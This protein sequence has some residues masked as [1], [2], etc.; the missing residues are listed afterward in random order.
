MTTVRTA[1]ATPELHVLH[2]SHFAYRHIGPRR[3]DVGE[4]LAVLGYDSI[5]AFIDA[6]V[7][8]GDPAPPPAR[9]C[10]PGRSEREVLQ[11]L[12][13]LAGM[14]RVFRSYIGMGYAGCFTPQVVQRNVLENPGWYTAYTPY[15]AEISQGRLEALLNFQ[16]VVSDL[17]GLRDRQRVA[18]RRGDRRRGGHE[19]DARREQGD[20]AIRSIWWTSTA[21]P[22]TIAVVQTRAEARGIRV[23]V[24]EPETFTFEPGV[25]GALVQ[26]PATDGAVRDFRSLARAGA[27]R[28]RARHRGD[29]SARAHPADAARRMGRRHRGRQQP[30]VRRADGLRRAARG[31]L[32][33]PRGVQ[34]VHARPHHRRLARPRRP[35]RAPHGAADPRAAHPPREGDEQRLHRAGAARGDGEHVRRVPRPG[36]APPHRGAGAH[37]RGAAGQR[38]PPAALPDRARRITSTRSASKSRSGPCP[39]CSTRPACAQINLRPLPPDPALHRARRDRDPRRPRR[40]DR[41]LLAERGAAVHAGRHR[42]QVGARASRRRSRARPPTSI[43]RS[44]TGTTR[45]PRCCAT[46]SGSRPGTSRSPRR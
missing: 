20:V 13:G 2:P 46:S 31:V 25:I 24:G 23:V 28:R 44:S 11:A 12:R 42:G 33:H 38:A 40:P 45:R 16:T 21:I 8:G 41:G 5:D 35:A 7:P 1:S 17:T 15:Q 30:A 43:I 4:M 27:R 22:Q 6:V 3:S 10:R 39:A 32:R 34:A 36:R 37:P 18:A 19:P 14:N 9:A 29:R 26:Y